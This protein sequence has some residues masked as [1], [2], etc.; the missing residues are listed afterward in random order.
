MKPTRRQFLFLALGM[1]YAGMVLVGATGVGAGI[2]IAANLGVLMFYTIVM[3]PVEQWMGSGAAGALRLIMTLTVLALL[4]AVLWGLGRLIA[5]AAGPL[6]LAPWTGIMLALGGI[7]F[8][9]LVWSPAREAEM[10]AVLDH[11][12]AELT[13]E[14]Q[15]AEYRA[16]RDAE[17]EARWSRFNVEIAT[18]RAACAE[19]RGEP[20]ALVAALAPVLTRDTFREALIELD[21]I[22]GPHALRCSL[23]LMARP[24]V[25][26]G[27]NSE[28]DVLLRLKRALETDPETAALAFET[29]DYWLSEP[30]SDLSESLDLL[31]GF[32]AI[33]AAMS[34]ADPLRARLG[35]VIGQLRRASGGGQ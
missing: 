23:A 17:D 12:L 21:E 10:Q 34:A 24:E 4:A 16:M 27:W 28:A 15:S 9:R 2:G 30:S 32:E 25:L 11:A 7:G 6:P 5:L 22:G 18:I 13:G 8:A 19:G 33:H 20:R 14:A 3:R 1:L 26:P 31:P 35:E 29:A